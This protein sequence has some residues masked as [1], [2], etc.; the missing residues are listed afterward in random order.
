[1]EKGGFPA[2]VSMQNPVIKL[3]KRSVFLRGKLVEVLERCGRG[4]IGAALSLIEITRVLFDEILHFDPEQPDWVDRDRFIL[5]KG[6]GCL[7]LY[8]LLADKG[9][10]PEH[11][12]FTACSFGSRLGG[13]PEYGLPGI[14]AATGALGHGLSIGVGMAL[15][16]RI[17][18]R[19]SRVFVVVGDGESQEGSIWEAAM[20][21]SK[22]QLDNL[23]VL[24]DRNHMQCYGPTEEIQ[25]LEPLA[26]KWA[27]FGF[28]V[29]ECDGHNVD[30]LHTELSSIPFQLGKPSVLICH[31]VKGMGFPSMTNN[32]DWHHK[33]RIKDDELAQMRQE[34]ELL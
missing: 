23:V 21:A 6:H 18:Q 11:E 20:G 30:A 8:L 34:L 9:F 15:A 26:E 27:S 10:F 5:S 7:A 29:R 28:R 1:M 12:L 32:P 19:K 22:H 17:D 2:K 4:H 31:T 16:A 14:E 3:D 25:S 33:S 24:V 13:H